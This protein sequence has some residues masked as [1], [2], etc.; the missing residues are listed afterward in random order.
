VREVIELRRRGFD[1]TIVSLRGRPTLIPDPEA[2]ALLPIVVYPPS[3]ARIVLGALAALVT[4]PVRSLRALGRALGDVAAAW[5]HP[6]QATK[7]AAM[8]PLAL[9][10]G[11][12]LPR[13]G[14]RLHAHFAS[15]PTA[16]ARMLAAFCGSSYSFTAHAFDIYVPENRR[17]LGRRIAGADLVL[18]CTAYNRDFLA[19]QAPS[20]ADA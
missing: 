2:R 7:Q 6:S 12:R 19:A 13:A 9:A 3:V 10:L 11:G 15:V 4:T 8:I 18:T 1:L 17:Q 5:R 16:V 14:C 20:E